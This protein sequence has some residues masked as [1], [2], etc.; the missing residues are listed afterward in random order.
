M[1]KFE[2]VNLSKNDRF[3]ENMFVETL[4]NW[5]L[6]HLDSRFSIVRANS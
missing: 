3:Y 1:S 4:I 2:E 5:D 6:N